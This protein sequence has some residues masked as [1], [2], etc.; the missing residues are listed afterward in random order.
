MIDHAANHVVSA[1][2]TMIS[3]GGTIVLPQ[4]MIDSPNS[5]I[6]STLRIGV[7]VQRGENLAS[8]TSALYGEWQDVCTEG[9]QLCRGRT[10]AAYR[11]A[12]RL[13]SL[14]APGSGRIQSPIGS[15]GDAETRRVATTRV[16]RL[17]QASSPEIAMD[18]DRSHR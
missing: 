1:A 9:N 10:A 2:S 11:L 16:H 4:S 6:V 17:I 8:G 15:R 5:M 12:A 13:F 14:A 7:L 3:R 18:L